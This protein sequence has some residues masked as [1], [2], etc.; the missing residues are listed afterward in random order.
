MRADFTRSQPPILPEF[1]ETLRW[2][3]HPREV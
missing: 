3:L 1:P 2:S